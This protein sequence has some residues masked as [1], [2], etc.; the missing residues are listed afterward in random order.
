MKN[1]IITIYQNIN[2]SYIKNKDGKTTNP[3][4]GISTRIDTKDN[5]L[6][7]VCYSVYAFD[8]RE[9]YGYHRKYDYKTFDEA[10]NVYD[11]ICSDPSNLES[12]YD[13]KQNIRIR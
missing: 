12:R 6:V 10:L 2:L 11:K 1:T 7:D 4:I 9:H 8:K 13:G 5:S 3:M